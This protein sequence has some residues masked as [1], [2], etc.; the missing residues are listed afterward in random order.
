[1]TSD[2]ALFPM[3]ETAER[4][5]RQTE[6]RHHAEGKT[7]FHFMGYGLTCDE[8]DALR[9]R[10]AGHCEICGIAEGDTPRGALSRAAARRMAQREGWTVNVNKTSRATGDDFCPDHK[11]EEG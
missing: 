4:P 5:T 8:Y 6:T 11:P 2:G 3:T 10:A 1:M 7:C 9:A